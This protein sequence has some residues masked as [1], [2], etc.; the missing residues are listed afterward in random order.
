MTAQLTPTQTAVLEAAA[1]RTDGNIEP[2][3]PTLRG[4]ARA[5]VIGGLLARGHR[6]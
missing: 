4:G 2:L 3:P 5:K 1:D 6:R